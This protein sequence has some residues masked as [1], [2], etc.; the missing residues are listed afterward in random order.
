MVIGVDVDWESGV[1]T[2]RVWDEHGVPRIDH[3][4]LLGTLAP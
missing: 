3:S 1:I 4:L 2:L